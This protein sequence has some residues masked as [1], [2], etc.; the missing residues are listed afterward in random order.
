[1][2][3]R[4]SALAAKKAKPQADT[5]KFEREIDALVYKLYDLSEEEISIIENNVIQD[6]TQGDTQNDTQGGTIDNWIEEQIRKN[7]KITTEELAKLSGKSVI[8]IKRHITKLSQIKYV[9]SGYS[10]HWEII[11]KF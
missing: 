11:N 5:S 2:Q 10:G 1:M 4:T 7:P 9:G 6:D 3:V 8:T